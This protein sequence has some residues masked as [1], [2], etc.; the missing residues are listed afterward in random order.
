MHHF[1]KHV[2][3]KHKDLDNLDDKRSYHWELKPDYTT[4]ELDLD[5]EPAKIKLDFNYKNFFDDDDEAKNQLEPNNDKGTLSNKKAKK[6]SI[7]EQAK[8]NSSLKKSDVKNKNQSVIHKYK[9]KK[10]PKHTEKKIK[11]IKNNS[12][13]GYR[14]INTIMKHFGNKNNTDNGNSSPIVNAIK[15]KAQS[16]M[17]TN[18]TKANDKERK[19]NENDRK[20]EKKSQDEKKKQIKAIKNN[21]TYDYD[22]IH[23][24]MKH[25]RN[26]TEDN[27]AHTKVTS[28][29]QAKEPSKNKL[30]KSKNS[31]KQKKRRRRFRRSLFVSEKS[32]DEG[33]DEKIIRKTLENDIERNKRNVMLDAIENAV[34]NFHYERSKVRKFDERTKRNEIPQDAKL[35]IG[36]RTTYPNPKININQLQKSLKRVFNKSQSFGQLG[37]LK[38]RD[39]TKKSGVLGDEIVMRRNHMKPLLSTK[40]IFRDDK[41]RNDEITERRQKIDHPAKEKQNLDQVPTN[42][43]RAVAMAMEQLKRDKMWGKVF[44]H[45]RPSGQLKVMVQETKKM[46]EEQ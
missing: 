29:N 1:A 26:K 45:V 14:D 32:E 10:S 17:N 25:K 38:K 22:N 4:N 24:I 41:M 9:D 30:S 44:V 12:G 42:V 43:A 33:E 27:A 28:V 40:S 6:N 20:K 21:S 5:E 3:R 2:G 23:I 46:E 19:V 35:K 11:D 37:A 34:D 31:E 15:E 13:D 16:I 8:I 39:L 7:T 18:S 36:K